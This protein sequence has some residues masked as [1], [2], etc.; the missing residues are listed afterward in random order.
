MIYGD[1]S[2]IRVTADSPQFVISEHDTIK[3]VLRLVPG[4]F[5]AGMG[6]LV[7]YVF[8]SGGFGAPIGGFP[9][10]IFSWLILTAIVI[11]MGIL[12]FCWGLAFILTRQRF[13]FDDIEKVIRRQ[14]TLGGIA[15]VSRKYPLRS[16]ERVRVDLR[17]LYPFGGRRHFVIACDGPARSLAIANF[18]SRKAASELAVEMASHLGLPFKDDCD[19]DLRCVS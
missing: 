14:R 11:L 2:A 10:I 6:G 13:L 4:L 5:L 19:A 7:L 15:I 17:S 16:F 1:D 8:L 18:S 12:P 9:K 3:A